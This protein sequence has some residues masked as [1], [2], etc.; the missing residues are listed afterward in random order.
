MKSSNSVFSPL[1]SIIE[2]I[3]RQR[4]AVVFVWMS[5][6]SIIFGIVLR[7]TS[8][9]ASLIYFL[10]I[11]PLW[12]MFHFSPR[13]SAGLI[14]MIGGVT[15]WLYLSSRH[16]SNLS[17]VVGAFS[18]ILVTALTLLISHQFLIKHAE[19]L[20]AIERLK[21]QYRI[22]AD[23][24]CDMEGWLDRAQQW[25]YLSPSC[26]QVTGFTVQEFLA[27]P[28]LLHEITVNEDRPLLNELLQR[29]EAEPD[30]SHVIEHRLQHKNGE[31]RWVEHTCRWIHWKDESG[32]QSGWRISLRDITEQKLAQLALEE[33]ER[34]YRDL[35]QYQGEGVVVADE[36][37]TFIFSNPAADAIIGVPTG[38]LVG[39]SV[40]EFVASEAMAKIAEE[41][42]KR[43][44]GLSST[45]ELEI[46]R[47]DGTRRTVLVTATPYVHQGKFLGTIANLRDITRRK[48]R[49]NQLHYA[50][51]HDMLTG[52]HNRAF[53]EE[54]LK[55]LEQKGL[56]PVGVLV[57]DVDNLKFINDTLGHHMGDQLLRRLGQLVKQSLREEGDVVAR[58]G[59]DEFV[60][61]MP[62]SNETAVRRVTERIEKAVHKENQSGKTPF[63]LEISV[64]GAVC[65]EPGGLNEALRQADLRMYENKRMKKARDNQRSS[66]EY[67]FGAM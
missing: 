9:S 19:D 27:R 33:S 64:G 17:F 31:V 13:F 4:P 47:P 67:L 10:L 50:S 21:E 44:R 49:E 52:L 5:V 29:A 36:R 46:Q 16:A 6:L 55:R 2:W 14:G 8:L 26:E 11:L 41:V 63:S 59:G 40:Y 37:Q 32:E 38:K 58:L 28:S 39:R 35:V 53:L 60:V 15:F 66:D 1:I 42:Q 25:L 30:R 48:E 56:F 51:T 20:K 3:V 65:T 54:E 24:S 7:L 12:S 43:R 22:V 62:R 18:P 57:I 23:Y 61:L 45:Y 34:R